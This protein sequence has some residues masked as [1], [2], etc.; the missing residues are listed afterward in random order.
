MF[1][2]QAMENFPSKCPHSGCRAKIFQDCILGIIPRGDVPLVNVV[3]RCRKCR[4][5]FGF[6]MPAAIVQ[7]FIDSLPEGG[8]LLANRRVPP[9]EITPKEESDFAELMM[10]NPQ[11]LFDEFRIAGEDDEFF[12]T[13]DDEEDDD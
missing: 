8:G 10:S 1:Q 6:G 9:K 7:R 5:T 12:G 4:K 13:H 3:L 2:F 11:K